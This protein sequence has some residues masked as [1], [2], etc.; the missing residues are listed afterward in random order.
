MPSC[1][2][3]FDTARAG[4]YERPVSIASAM[5]RGFKGTHGKGTLELPADWPP[6]IRGA[7][8]R[9]DYFF[10]ASHA[11]QH[12]LTAGRMY[13]ASANADRHGW[14]GTYGV[15]SSSWTYAGWRGARTS[16]AG[17]TTVGPVTGELDL[18]IKRLTKLPKPF[19]LDGSL[20]EWAGTKP[21]AVADG[22]VFT[23]PVFTRYSV[24]E[25]NNWRG[26]KDLSAKVWLATDGEAL[27]VAAEV[28]DDTHVNDMTGREIH[29]GDALQVG[30]MNA[31]GVHYN[32]CAALTAKGVEIQKWDP[33]NDDRLLKSAQCAIK[34]DDSA[35]G[36]AGPA[37]VT[38]YEFR[39][40][41]ADFGVVPGQECA[42][43]FLVFDADGRMSGRW[44]GNKWV[45]TPMVR[46]LQW[47]PERTE[48]F[49]RR[50]YP[51]FVVGE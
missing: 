50:A 40:P 42:F 14:T 1:W 10:G 27:L 20:D 31:A 9:N 23:F 38:R 47:V 17:D 18:E 34:R 7:I 16:P 6:D 48:P 37:G 28:T 32:V 13:A 19:Q 25:S 22:A 11:P 26:T 51:A 36:G 12:L 39:L 44:E 3:V 46:R 29:R 49:T 30:M 24:A 43:Y 8:I 45:P 35:S 41:L 21:V 2:G 5:G 4:V 15:P 33:E